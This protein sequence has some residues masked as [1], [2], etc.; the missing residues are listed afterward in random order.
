MKSKCIIEG[1]E[2]GTSG[3]AE[4]MEVTDYTGSSSCRSIGGTSSN[5]D[6]MVIRAPQPEIDNALSYDGSERSG[7]SGFDK[8]LDRIVSEDRDV[9][10]RLANR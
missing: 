4:F 6:S 10:R 2:E 3:I 7:R 1:P 9:L 5:L 8:E